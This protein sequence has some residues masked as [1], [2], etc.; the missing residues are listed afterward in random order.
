MGE[1]LYT[2][3]FFTALLELALCCLLPQYFITFLQCYTNLL[4]QQHSLRLL[5]PGPHCHSVILQRT[6]KG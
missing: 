4:Y 3:V 2:H 5:K 6:Y 1:T